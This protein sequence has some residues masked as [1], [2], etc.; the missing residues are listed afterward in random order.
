MC[1][2][3][4]SPNCAGLKVLGKIEIKKPEK[5]GSS[6]TSDDGRKKRKRKKITTGPPQT[7]GG[8]SGGGR[9]DRGRT[10]GRNDEPK[11]VSAK[12]IEDKIKATM[13]R[14]QG[15]GGKKKR[16]R[17]RRDNRDPHAAK[18]RRPCA[19]SRPPTKLQLTEFVTA[20]ELAN[21]MDV[22]SAKLSLPV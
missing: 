2:S 7:G 13:A 10:G 22:V 3:R 11:E 6:S 21:M 1:T 9:N 12:D 16:Q 15:G 4:P 18:S 14:L 5:R 19:T 17:Q 20:Q 8:R